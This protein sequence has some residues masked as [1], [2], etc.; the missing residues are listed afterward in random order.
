MQSLSSNHRTV[1]VTSFIPSLSPIQGPAYPLH[2][3][4]CP[5]SPL[6]YN[7]T[8]GEP[9]QGWGVPLPL[10]WPPGPELGS[11][12]PIAQQGPD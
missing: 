6:S 9:G 5:G 11:C 8:V 12:V 4:I 3:V 2:S 1:S 10:A 7:I